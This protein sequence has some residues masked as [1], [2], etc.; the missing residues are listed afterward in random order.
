MTDPRKAYLSMTEEGKEINTR[1]NLKFALA[2]STQLKTK[3]P[4]AAIRSAEDP[5]L[6]F[7]IQTK[8]VRHLNRVEA[9]GGD[10]VIDTAPT[11]LFFVEG[12]SDIMRPSKKS[13]F[14][15][16]EKLVTNRICEVSC[17]YEGIRGANAPTLLLATNASAT[18]L[19]VFGSNDQNEMDELG[20]R[21]IAIPGEESNFFAC[22]V[23]IL[24]DK[25]LKL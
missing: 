7:N 22:P 2:L 13:Q 17:K 14:N 19:W 16:F 8:E 20:A 5:F 4:Q 12:V 1:G 9:F 6:E 21:Y 18:V 23:S 24:A 10:L 11:E 15:N 25:L 3:I